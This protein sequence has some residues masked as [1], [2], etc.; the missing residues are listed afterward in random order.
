MNTTGDLADV[1]TDM[2]IDYGYMDVDYIQ[3]VC[4]FSQ[5]HILLSQNS[6]NYLFYYLFF[7][8][9]CLIAAHCFK[10]SNLNVSIPSSAILVSLGRYRLRDWR[11]EGSVNREVESYV[12]HPDYRH[13]YT[14]DSD[15][16]ILVLRL[17]VEFSPTIK[18]ICIWSSA[19]GLHRIVNESGYVVGWGKDEY[20]N[21]YLAEPRMVKVPVVSQVNKFGVFSHLYDLCSLL[22][23][24]NCLSKNKFI[25]R[26]LTK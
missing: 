26:L 22:V 21:P 12:I 4:V 7:P 5:G 24:Q 13:Q 16:A 15:L 10:D 14:A 18:P 9:F 8:F 6:G 11:E 2:D 23:L 20:G 25:S 1:H 3:K 17:P 19:S